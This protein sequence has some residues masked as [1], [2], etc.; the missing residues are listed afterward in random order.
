M[1]GTGIPYHGVYHPAR[2]E[3]TKST[4]C[5]IERWPEMI[6]SISFFSLPETLIN[7]TG[8]SA[9]KARWF[10]RPHPESMTERANK[11]VRIRLLLISLSPV[12]TRREAA[13]LG[14]HKQNRGRQAEPRGCHIWLATPHEPNPDPRGCARV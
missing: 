12:E 7:V 4:I 9:G 10:A 13:R 5:S 6:V 11:H 3:S 1:A 2:F 8:P 14:S